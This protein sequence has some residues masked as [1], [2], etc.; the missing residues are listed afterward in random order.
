MGCPACIH[1]LEAFPVRGVSSV[2][3]LSLASRERAKDISFGAVKH[4]RIRPG[5]T[6][7]R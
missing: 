2:L 7:L 6:H 5:E 4:G 1:Q 3:Q